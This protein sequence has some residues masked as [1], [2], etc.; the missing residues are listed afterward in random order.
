MLLLLGMTRIITG[1]LLTH[2]LAAWGGVETEDSM[3]SD[4]VAEE[5]NEAPWGAWASKIAL[6]V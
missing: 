5:D 6:Q 1:A 2:L 4:V 3:I